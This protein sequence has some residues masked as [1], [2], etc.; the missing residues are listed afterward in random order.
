MF[1]Y[2]AIEMI[3]H[4]ENQFNGQRRFLP[5]LAIGMVV[6]KI[7]TRLVWEHI[8]NAIICMGASHSY[9]LHLFYSLSALVCMYVWMDVWMDGWM[10]ACMHT[11]MYACAC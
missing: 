6:L 1:A 11:C 4:L 10:D 3:L 9:P 8:P 2:V 7:V 5:Q